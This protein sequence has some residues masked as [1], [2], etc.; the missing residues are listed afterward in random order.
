MDIEPAS[1]W[2]SVKYVAISDNLK[3]S[4]ET[5]PNIILKDVNK[6][7]LYSKT[8]TVSYAALQRGDTPIDLQSL[9]GSLCKAGTDIQNIAS[10]HLNGN[11]FEVEISDPDQRERLIDHGFRFGGQRIGC[12]DA[13]QKGTIIT[14]VGVPPEITNSQLLPFL[15]MHGTVRTYYHVVKKVRIGGR[16]VAIK[17]GNRVFVVTAFDRIPPKNFKIFGHLVRCFFTLPQKENCSEDAWEEVLYRTGAVNEIYGLATTPNNDNNENNNNNNNDKNTKNNDN[18][19]TDSSN[20]NNSNNNNNNNNNN[21]NNNNTTNTNENNATCGNTHSATDTDAD[22]NDAVSDCS[23]TSQTTQ[24]LIGSPPG[25]F[26]TPA[27]PDETLSQSVINPKWLFKKTPV[28]GRQDEHNRNITEEEEEGTEKEEKDK[29]EEEKESGQP[30]VRLPTKN[31]N[32]GGGKET[33]NRNKINRTPLKHLSPGNATLP[34]ITPRVET[35]YSPANTAT[36]PTTNKALSAEN[37]AKCNTTPALTRKTG[38]TTFNKTNTPKSIKEIQKVIY[39]DPRSQQLKLGNIEVFQ[40]LPNTQ[41]HMIFATLFLKQDCRSHGVDYKS[42]AKIAPQEWKDYILADPCKA[43]KEEAVYEKQQAMIDKYMR[44]PTVRW[45][46]S[47]EDQAKI[48]T[49]YIAK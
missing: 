16:Y 42:L 17:N 45:N 3:A 30:P 20:N 32:S 6:D 28:E 7:D 33:K 21:I 47:L 14:L 41:I 40:V 4:T 31:N 38:K 27:E 9:T 8:I 46:K 13:R 34:K 39:Y 24:D 15:Q 25:S 29:V 19:N 49:K 5:V 1:E 37:L 10:I 43:V 36:T 44:N 18:D 35:K 26:P 2:G 12:S 48:L 11:K 23:Q 22:K